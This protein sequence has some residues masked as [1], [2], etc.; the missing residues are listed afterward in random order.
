ML[1]IVICCNCIVFNKAQFKKVVICHMSYIHITCICN[2]IRSMKQQKCN[3]KSVSMTTLHAKI[4][5]R[6]IMYFIYFMFYR[7]R[8]HQKYISNDI[9]VIPFLMK[10]TLSPSCST[11]CL[12]CTLLYIAGWVEVFV[13]GLGFT[14]K[15]ITFQ[16][17]HAMSAWCARKATFDTGLRR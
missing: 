6:H 12:V 16:L 7:K 1:R 3:K 5:P 15:T 13:S 17:Y 11:L 9:P 14:P 2:W 8:E 4:V 10:K